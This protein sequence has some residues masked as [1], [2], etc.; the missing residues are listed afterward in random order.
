MTRSAAAQPA[1]EKPPW[2]FRSATATMARTVAVDLSLLRKSPASQGW[3]PTRPALRL[4]RPIFVVGA[5]RSGTSYLGDA[6]GRLSGVSYHFE[7]IATKYAAQQYATRDW[8]AG[9]TAA[10]LRLA[11][12]LLL[13]SRMEWSKRLCDKTPQACF[14]IDLLAEQFP[15]AQF[16]HIIRDGR[17]AATS[18]RE[19]PWLRA[20]SAAS[21]RFEP[22]GARWGGYPRFWTEI[23]R[24]AEF[25][26]TTDLHR[27]IWAWRRFTEEALR[28]TQRLP[29][30]RHLEL[31]YERLVTQPKETGAA[32]AEFLGEPRQADVLITHL[33]NSARPASVGRWHSLMPDE[34]AV[35]QREAGSLLD[36]LG[37]S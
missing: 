10:Y 15:D 18:Y 14:L 12:R 5:P 36:A 21:R 1:D 35:F 24:R 37:Y 22:G 13:T 4:H 32:L 31:R 6:V 8:D 19:K 7:P 11:Y 2:R 25:R 9:R 17:D 3:R 16:V 33:V 20:D 23:D 29:G 28:Q 27:C 30:D 26:E 34:Q